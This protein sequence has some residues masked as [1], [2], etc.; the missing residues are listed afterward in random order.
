LQ[1]QV[2]KKDKVAIPKKQ[3]E[4]EEKVEPNL[5]QI[6]KQNTATSLI[7]QPKPKE[8]IMDASGRFDLSGKLVNQLI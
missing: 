2:K 5:G 8:V 1:S 6:Q 7:Q 4:K 3:S